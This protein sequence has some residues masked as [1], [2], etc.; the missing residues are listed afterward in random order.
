MTF[1]TVNSQ[2]PD[3]CTALVGGEAVS[4]LRGVVDDPKG[5]EVAV[6]DIPEGGD[7]GRIEN[8]GGSGV[9]CIWTVLPG[10]VGPRKKDDSVRSGFRPGNVS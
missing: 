2:A 10:C 7:I 9:G 5:I 1:A 6:G 3:L 4:T 8:A